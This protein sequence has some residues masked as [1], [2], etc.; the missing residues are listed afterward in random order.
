MG[1]I[2]EKNYQKLVKNPLPEVIATIV[3]EKQKKHRTEAKTAIEKQ[4]EKQALVERIRQI[5]QKW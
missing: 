3:Q 4:L 2:D 5:V 1:R